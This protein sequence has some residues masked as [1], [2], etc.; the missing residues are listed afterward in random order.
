MLNYIVHI[1]IDFMYHMP[2]FVL[3]IIILTLFYLSLLNSGL[4]QELSTSL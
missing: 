3:T 4:Q 2:D 1:L